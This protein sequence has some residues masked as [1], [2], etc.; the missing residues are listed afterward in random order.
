MNSKSCILYLL[1]VFLINTMPAQEPPQ[2]RKF[3]FP[4]RNSLY[5]QN[6]SIFPTLYYDRVIPISDHFGIIP[7]LGF[8]HGLGYGNSITFEPSIFFGGNKNYGEI[9]VGNWVGT[10]V[11]TMNYRYIGKKGLL[12]K[13]GFAAGGIKTSPVVGVGYS[14]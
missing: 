10:V 11:F 5:L 9:G 8:E 4:R 13:V 14:F 1:F 3:D 6:H 7:K 2:K 12:I